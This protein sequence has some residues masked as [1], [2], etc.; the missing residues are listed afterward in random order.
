MSTA[1]F[2]NASTPRLD[3][4]PA[5]WPV[6]VAYVAAFLIVLVATAVLVLGVAAV[7]TR[8]AGIDE[9]T[10]AAVHFALSAPGILSAA[11]LSGATFLGVAIVTAA[12]LG[13]DVVTQ[14]RV[15][16]S[17]ATPLG[18]VA[19]A[20]GTSALSFAAGAT[21]DL[22]G[23]RQAG[24][25][26]EEIASSLSHARPLV[27]V[28][29]IVLLG[30]GPGIAEETFFRGLMQTRFTARLG[31]WPGIV[32]TALLFGLIHLDRVQS[33]L[34]FLLGLYLGWTAE[35]LGGIRPSMLAHAVNNALFVSAACL[36]DGSGHA[37]ERREDVIAIGAGLAVLA[38][39][40]V[41]LR[42]RLS[43]HE[44]EVAG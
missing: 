9:L 44:P 27:F 38:A 12:L 15:G 4:R 21:S 36:S 19:A 16:P 25:T 6:L 22:V 7:R 28:L 10:E 33:P 43:V 37:T 18:L 31:R 3:R 8:G 32:L 42:S 11:S 23:L 30:V 14:L 35:R 17:R 34:A 26:M 39:A 40:T 41:L 20:L 5:I 29:A 24:G 2:M 13:K 1:A